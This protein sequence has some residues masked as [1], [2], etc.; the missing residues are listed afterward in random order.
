MDGDAVIIGAVQ[1]SSQADVD[2]NLSRAARLTGEAARRG[3]KVVLLPENF[4]YLGDEEG[5]RALAEDLPLAT[6]GAD[7]PQSSRRGAGLGPI[8]RRLAEVARQHAIHLL[9]GGMPERS[10]DQDLPFNT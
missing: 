1:L 2:E 3:A 6:A 8:G 10:G 9:A 4:A 5:K 7:A